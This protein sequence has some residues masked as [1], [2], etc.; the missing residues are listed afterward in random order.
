MSVSAT[1]VAAIA[2]EKLRQ[3]VAASATF[4]TATGTSTRTAALTRVHARNVLGTPNRPVAIVSMGD[5]LH[6]RLI[7]GGAQ[8]YLRP[9]GSLFLFLAIDTPP[10]HFQD[11]V[12]AEWH[13]WNFLSGVLEDVADLSAA[14]DTSSPFTP[15]ESHLS[16]TD[17]EVVNWG[18]TR[19]EDWESL[20]R[21][22]HA[23]VRV[24]WGDG[25]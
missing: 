4:Q 2:A 25:E 19:E 15:A 18:G 22:Y 20:G 10:E 14:D 1:N 9:S 7:G 8:N 23:A 21:F 13:A 24:Q 5:S 3:M 11:Q 16:I 12:S 17:I 6:F